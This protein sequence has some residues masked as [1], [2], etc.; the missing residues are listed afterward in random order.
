MLTTDATHPKTWSWNKG[1]CAMLSHL[2]IQ[3]LSARSRQGRRFAA[4]IT[5]SF[6]AAALRGRLGELETSEGNEALLV[7]IAE[8]IRQQPGQ[9]RS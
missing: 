2:T 6:R 4:A 9:R 8:L 1:Y 3:A 5:T 7:F